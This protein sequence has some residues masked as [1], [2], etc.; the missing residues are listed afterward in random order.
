MPDLGDLLSLDFSGAG[1]GAPSTFSSLADAIRPVAG[2]SYANVS[3]PSVP[4]QDVAP[5][6]TGGGF[7]LPSGAD[8][9]G[10]ASDFGSVAKAALPFVQLGT[11]GLGIASGVK[12]GQQLAEQTNI[13][14]RAEQRQEQ[15]A[16][17]AA[18]AAAPL[19]AFSQQQLNLAQ[20]G[21]LDPATEAQ[22]AQWAQGWKQKIADFAAKSGQGNSEQVIAWN[23]WIDQQ[24]IAARQQGIQA[25]ESGAVGAAGTAGGILSAGAGAAGGAGAAA[26]GQQSGLTNLIAEANKQLSA[27]TGSVG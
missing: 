22:L 10:A 11:A 4:T 2:T 14:K 18:S 26:A 21:K 15:I 23:Q 13:A 9:K 20:Q 7:S 17:H 27:L 25:M 16:G 1:E 12:G 19:E 6:D 5:P 8:I 24:V 3:T